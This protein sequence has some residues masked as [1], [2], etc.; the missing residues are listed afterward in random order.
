VGMGS[1]T[2]AIKA[3]CPRHEPFAAPSRKGDM[4]KPT[5]R[6]AFVLALA[7]AGGIAL[8]FTA[9]AKTPE[10]PFTSVIRDG[11]FEIRDYGTQVVAEV[12]VADGRGDPASQGFNPLAGYI[13]GG[14]APRTKI[15]MTAPVTRQQGTQIAMTA[16]VTRQLAGDAWKVRFIMPEGSRLATMPAPNNPNVRLLEEPGKR[17]AVVRFS[18]LSGADVL[19]RKTAELNG[20]LAG[21][22]LVGIGKPVIALYDPPWTM[23]FMRR[24]EVWIE[25][26]R[27]N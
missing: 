24:N 26:A 16:P 6:A 1:N 9:S 22:R 11:A 4:N 20:F 23:P 3:N 13:F 25:I 8:P 17:Y 10:P 7:L 18:G 27:Q 12:I 14:N 5:K 19:A 15:A 2:S 21:R